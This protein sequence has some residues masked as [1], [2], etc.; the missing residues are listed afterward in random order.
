MRSAATLTRCSEDRAYKTTSTT[1]PCNPTSTIQP[2]PRSSMSRPTQKTTHLDHETA[3]HEETAR[4]RKNIKFDPLSPLS[5]GTVVA[6]L[7]FRRGG[8]GGERV[9]TG[10]KA[11][12]CRVRGCTMGDRGPVMCGVLSYRRCTLNAVWVVHPRPC[13]D[14]VPVRSDADKDVAQASTRQETVCNV[15]WTA[16]RT[17]TVMDQ[18]VGGVVRTTRVENQ[19]TRLAETRYGDVRNEQVVDE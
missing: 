5:P 14:T 12:A 17:R 13:R 8:A 2:T 4:T 16:A 9:G 19:T 3:R 10:R 6:L 7:S 15:D 1:S 11:E 18:G